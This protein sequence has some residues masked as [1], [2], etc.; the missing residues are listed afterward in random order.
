MFVLSH[1]NLVK[2]IRG[3]NPVI[4]GVEPIMDN[5][6]QMASIDLSLGNRVYATR[7]SSFPDEGQSVEQLLDVIKKRQ[8]AFDLPMG[9]EKLLHR[10]QTY[11]VPLN[12]RLALPKGF[13]AKFSPKSSIGRI[14]VFVRIVADGVPWFDHVPS[15]YQGRLY[16]EIAPLSG[17]I[18]I[19]AR[20]TL[21]QMRL[22][23]DGPEL[24]EREIIEYQT[25]EGIVWGK[26]GKA[27]AANRLKVEGPGIHM[28]VDL[29]RE[30]VGF[31][32]RDPFPDELSLAR[33]ETYEADDFWEPIPRPRDGFIVLN[34]GRFYLLATKERIKVPK[35]LCGDIPPYDTKSGEFRSHYAGFFD[36]G[37]GGI[38]SEDTGTVGVMEVRGRELPFLLKD[39]QPIC[40]MDFMRLDEVPDKLYGIGSHYTGAG[41][42]LAK[43]FRNRQEVWKE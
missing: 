30:V 37:F 28:H 19:R 43:F 14:D 35:T 26:N 4:T 41:P 39:G 27:I 15:E 38:A 23:V 6:I 9:E 18:L 24:S 16:L 2:L 1:Q 7:A 17:D 21:V 42:S 11:L 25:S 5:Q 31:M 32:A 13:S 22:H 10:G 40:R 3:R 33:V 29:D 20:Q 36:P 8:Y 12:E 34:P